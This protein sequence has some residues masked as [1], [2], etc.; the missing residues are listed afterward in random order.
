MSNLKSTS[1]QLKSTS[2]QIKPSNTQLK[3]SNTQLNPSNIQPKLNTQTSLE[4]F[5]IYLAVHANPTRFLPFP[6]EY[7][8]NPLST[9]TSNLTNLASQEESK[10]PGMLNKSKKKRSLPRLY[11]TDAPQTQRLGSSFLPYTE[12]EYDRM[13]AD[14]A[15]LEKHPEKFPRLLKYITSLE[16]DMSEHGKNTIHPSITEYEFRYSALTER[17]RNIQYP[18]RWYLFHGS[19]LGN[20]HSILRNG[21]KNMSN[22]AYMS[23]G[24]AS[25]SGVYL[26]DDI[27]V[28]YGYG[29]LG[30]K[31][32]CVAVIEILEDPETYKVRVSSHFVVPKDEILVARYLYKVAGSPNFDGKEVLQY[33]KK[34]TEGRIKHTEAKKRLIT[35]EE[36]LTKNNIEVISKEGFVWTII[37]EQMLFKLYL[38]SFPFQPVVIQPAYKLEKNV[39]HT[40]ASH[41]GHIDDYGHSSDDEPEV[42][43]PTDINDTTL[44][45][46]NIKDVNL[47]WMPI[48]WS[49]SYS[50]LTVLNLYKEAVDLSSLTMSTTE[51]PPL[52]SADK[53]VAN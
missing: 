39:P 42:K 44:K 37:Y 43:E 48:D 2:T 21:L 1:T 45:L 19:P 10:V 34:I 13:K 28:S 18:K 47:P 17:I 16:L 36:T 49:P 20:W 11:G 26:S 53:N 3:P 14:L 31:I 27:R 51:I 12:E 15:Q 5:L 41:T 46:T 24:A 22:T 4:Q 33:Y 38:H 50:L 40:N 8:S 6:N 32:S 7:R 35:E 23:S 29:G 52:I 9:Q 30:S 25:G